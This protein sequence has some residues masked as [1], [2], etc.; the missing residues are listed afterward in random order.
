MAEAAAGGG[1]GPEGGTVVPGGGAAAP[2]GGAGFELPLLLFA[3]FRSIIDAL[4]RDLAEQGHPETRPA[5]GFALQAVGREGAG[6]SEIGRR[7]G[8]SKQAAGKTV[9]KLEALGYVERAAD[10]ADG[11]RTVIRLTSH[12][13]D[14]LARSAEG[15]DRL[16]AQWARALGDERLTALEADLRTMAPANAFRLDAAGWFT[17]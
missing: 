8:V 1:G 15:F 14:L 4:H 12:G 3:G 10:P 5:Y 13:T 2:G 11:R 17:G 16:R 9:E 7:L 6:I